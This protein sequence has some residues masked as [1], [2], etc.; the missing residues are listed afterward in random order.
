MIVDIEPIAKPRQTQSDKWKKRPIVQRYRAYKDQL[1]WSLLGQKVL[2]ELPYEFKVVFHMSMPNG[3]SE[4]RKKQFHFTPHQQMPDIDNLLKGFM[5]ALYAKDQMIY[6]IHV[7][8]IWDY[9]GK[10]NMEF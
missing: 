7:E 2:A 10:I 6:S 1:R 3:W 4:K 5:D 9:T 8:K